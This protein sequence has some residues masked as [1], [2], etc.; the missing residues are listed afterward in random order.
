MASKKNTNC[1]R[2]TSMSNVDNNKLATKGKNSQREIISQDGKFDYKRSIAAIERGR[3]PGFDSE[4]HHEINNDPDSHRGGDSDYVYSP[5]SDTGKKQK[6]NK[7]KT[8]QR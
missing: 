8:D 3:S 6:Q 2:T 5:S 4:I 7:N 1:D